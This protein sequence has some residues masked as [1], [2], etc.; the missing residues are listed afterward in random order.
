MELFFKAHRENKKL[1]QEATSEGIGVALSTYRK[2]ERSGSSN[3]GFE[4]V[5]KFCQFC[6]ITLNELKYLPGNYSDPIL[7][8]NIEINRLNNNIDYLKEELTNTIISLKTEITQ[9]RK[10]LQKS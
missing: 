8:K 4:D 3:V 1:T 9:L 5:E 2:W 7:E 6:E 10:N